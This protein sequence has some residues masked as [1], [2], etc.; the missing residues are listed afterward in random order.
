MTSFCCCDPTPENVQKAF[1]DNKIVPDV[2]NKPPKE[3]LRVRKDSSAH[4]RK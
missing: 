1:I 3:F 2:L 4:T